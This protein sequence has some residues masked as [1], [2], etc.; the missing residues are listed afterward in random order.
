MGY[1][2]MA[3]PLNLWLPG[4]QI[5]LLPCACMCSR[6]K[7]LAQSVC[8]LVCVTPP[9]K[10]K[11]FCVLPAINRRQDQSTAFSYVAK[12]AVN[13]KQVISMSTR[14]VPSY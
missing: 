10:K 11:L 12:D 14:S 4:L 6:V 3:V 13:T 2:P 1:I 7:H 9:P 8:I 5:S